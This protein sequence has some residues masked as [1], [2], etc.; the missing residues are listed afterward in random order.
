MA[1]KAENICRL[2]LCGKSVPTSALPHWKNVSGLPSTSLSL[3]S[4][5][6]SSVI[7]ASHCPCLALTVS[8]SLQCFYVSL[9]LL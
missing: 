7:S 8:A 1:S 6:A 2:V 9:Q 5:R 3:L 4:H